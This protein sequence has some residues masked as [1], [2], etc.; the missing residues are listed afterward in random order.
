M[1]IFLLLK[2]GF[3]F[4]YCPRKDANL[5]EIRLLQ[6]LMQDF[7]IEKG[8]TKFVDPENFRKEYKGV[9]ENN[10]EICNRHIYVGKSLF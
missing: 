2:F 5:R 4:P 9:E 3:R 8:P 7:L 6:Q 1:K 10:S